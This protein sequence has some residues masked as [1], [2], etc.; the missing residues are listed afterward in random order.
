MPD[1]AVKKSGATFSLPS[2]VFDPELPPSPIH[3]P[4]GIALE[5]L[6]A[7]RSSDEFQVR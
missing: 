4:S 2:P 5:L 1:S 7:Y 6:A 3:A